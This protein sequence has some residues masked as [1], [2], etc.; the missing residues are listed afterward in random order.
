M[1]YVEPYK[2]VA[3]EGTDN[4]RYWTRRSAISIGRLL[5]NVRRQ[6][7]PDAK[8]YRLDALGRWFE[9]ALDYS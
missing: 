5:A 4:E 9:I 8:L 1:V 3:F 6:I 2:V 7:D